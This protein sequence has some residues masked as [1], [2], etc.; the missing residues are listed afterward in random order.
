M[1]HTIVRKNWIWSVA[2]REYNQS[3]CLDIDSY[4]FNRE[5]V[6]CCSGP[7]IQL[8]EMEID[9]L[10]GILLVILALLLLGLVVKKLQSGLKDD[11]V[12]VV[13]LSASGTE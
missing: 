8:D 2:G 7:I 6:N 1:L 9:P 12:L 11:S 4:S 13:G 3:L 5:S 10:V